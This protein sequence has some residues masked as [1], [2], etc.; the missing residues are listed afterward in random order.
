[1]TTTM[2]LEVDI[3][4]KSASLISL[5]LHHVGTFAFFPD[6]SCHTSSHNVIAVLSHMTAT[7]SA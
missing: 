6:A 5:Q 4:N 7:V 1:M 3:A 2:P